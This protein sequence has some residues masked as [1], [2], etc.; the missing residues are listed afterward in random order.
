MNKNKKSMKIFSCV[1]STKKYLLENNIFSE[2]YF[3]FLLNRLKK[4]NKDSIHLSKLEIDRFIIFTKRNSIRIRICKNRLYSINKIIKILHNYH[5]KKAI[6]FIIIIIDYKIHRCKFQKIIEFFSN[7]IQDKFFFFL[8][9]KKF[10]LEKTF[11]TNGFNKIN[12]VYNI[13]LSSYLF[14]EIFQFDYIFKI[15][16]IILCYYLKSILHLNYDEKKFFFSFFRNSLN[17]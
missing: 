2:F 7:N 4:I 15:S 5:L 1:K 17:V 9:K 8:F 12:I 3:K 14:S 11:F 6:R 16:R 13:R 10:Q